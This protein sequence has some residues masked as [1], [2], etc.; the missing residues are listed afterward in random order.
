M[1]TSVEKEATPLQ[2]GIFASIYGSPLLA[3]PGS[4]PS[5]SPRLLSLLFIFSSTGSIGGLPFFDQF[6]RADG[7]LEYFENTLSCLYRV[8][9]V[10]KSSNQIA[11]AAFYAVVVSTA[12]N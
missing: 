4:P 10:W 9:Q 11:A 12:S 2:R 1:I 5:A 3:S 7:H 8:F 6:H